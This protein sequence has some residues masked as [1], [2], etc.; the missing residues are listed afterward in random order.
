MNPATGETRWRHE[1][2]KRPT[3]LLA[4]AGG[5][6][7]TGETEGYLM[8]LDAR[9]GEVLWHF[10]TGAEIKAPPISYSLRGK[11]YIAIAAGPNVIAFKLP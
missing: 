7:F 11:Q 3:G 6:I 1:T 9:T 4:T 2:L 5:L 10:Q 8:A